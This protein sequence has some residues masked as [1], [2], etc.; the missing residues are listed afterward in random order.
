MT[1]EGEATRLYSRIRDNSSGSWS[2]FSHR[3]VSRRGTRDGAKR[4]QLHHAR[5]RQRHLFFDSQQSQG[6][7]QVRRYLVDL[8]IVAIG[9]ALPHTLLVRPLSRTGAARLGCS[10]SRISCMA[11]SGSCSKSL[12][13]K[14]SLCSRRH[15]CAP[16]TELFR[17]SPASPPKTRISSRNSSRRSI[18]ASSKRRTI[19]HRR[20][21]KGRA[22]DR[23]YRR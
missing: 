22:T 3:S 9:I 23:A 21:T 16:L 13:T 10:T 15:C 8:D 2:V 14:A 18:A 6:G 19:S 4:P 5:R 7:V 20:S 12:V 11:H 17:T 1:S